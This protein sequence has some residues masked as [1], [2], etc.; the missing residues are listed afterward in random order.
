MKVVI[1]GGTRPISKK[2]GAISAGIFTA[3]IAII[4]EKNEISKVMPK[5][6]AVPII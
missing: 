2:F 5:N 6:I 1:E 3:L 4:T